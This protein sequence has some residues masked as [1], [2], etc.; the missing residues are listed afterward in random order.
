MLTIKTNNV[1]RPLLS[2]FDLT[3]AEI[4]ELDYIENILDET[5]RFF[6]YRGQIYDLCEFDD[7]RAD[8][9]PCDEP[10]KAWQMRQSDSYFSG[11]VVRYHS[12]ETEH[13]DE[14]VV[15]GRYTC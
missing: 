9:E 6:R 11:V 12:D 3:Q 4:Q 5:N 10:F 13:F 14:T 8:R 15:V 1:P 7:I 2:G